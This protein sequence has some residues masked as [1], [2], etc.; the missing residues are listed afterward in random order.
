[1]VKS[2]LPVRRPGTVRLRHRPYGRHSRA[3][4]RTFVVG[5][6]LI[7]AATVLVLAAIG[8][9]W[10]VWSGVNRQLEDRAIAALAPDDPNIRSQQAPADAAAPAAGAA[11]NILIAGVTPR[12]A[13]AGTAGSGTEG[14]GTE[15]SGTEQTGILLLAHAS[16]DGSR[17]DLV[18]IPDDLLVTAPACQ[19]WDPATRTSGPDPA[20]TGSAQWRIGEAYAVGGP[21]CTV[22]AVQ[23]ATGLRVD[24][25]V[26]IDRTGFKDIVDAMGGIEVPG[27]VAVAADGRPVAAGAP[28]RTIDGDQ[29]LVLIDA[30]LD[31]DGPANGPDALARQRALVA[32]M[33]AQLTSRESLSDPVALNDTL[34]AVVGHATTAN[35]TVDDLAR[36]ALAV[37]GGRGALQ[38]YTLPTEADPSGRGRRPTAATAAF[39][40]ALVADVAPP[41]GAG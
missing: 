18:S 20:A 17:I 8:A 40:E 5:R 30:F 28:G 39:T 34:H 14:S 21:P 35:V 3:R 27:S 37:Q 15:G 16:A 10:W 25:L 19:T 23:A 33:L 6:L 7:A 38:E 26:M 24:R 32:A 29:A 22:R 9:G 4:E 31:A 41:A 11:E 13:G 12:R 2:D 1:M 36:L